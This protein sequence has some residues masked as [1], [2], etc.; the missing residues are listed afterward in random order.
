MSFYTSLTGLNAATAMLGVTSN[1]IANV[2]TTGFKRSRADFGDIFATSPL[3]KASS[4]VGQ[5][6]SLKQVSQEF[7][8]GNISFSSNALDLAIT[9]D[10]FFPMRSAD[11]LQETY[12]RNGSFLLN[13]Q[14]NVVNS[15]GQ[16]LMAATVDSTGSA[17]VNDRVVLTIP[18]KTSGEAKQT[19]AVSLGLN[20]PADAPVISDEFNR[21]NPATYNKSTAFTVYDAGGN[22]YLATV[23]YVKTK[24]A[25]QTSPTNTWQTHVY[26]GEDS[27]NA[28]LQQASNVN[29]EKLYVNQYGQLAPYSLVKDELT[30]AKTMLFSLNDLTDTQKS[31][32]A[33]VPGKSITSFDF[34][35]GD[36]FKLRNDT[37]NAADLALASVAGLAANDSTVLTT[38]DMVSAVVTAAVS[39]MRYPKA[40]LPERYAQGLRAA[41][42]CTPSELSDDAVLL[43]LQTNVNTAV[44]SLSGTAT[45][46][47]VATTAEIKEARDNISYA[48]ILLAVQTAEADTTLTI[49]DILSTDYD[50]QRTTAMDALAAAYWAED[51]PAQYLVDVD[52]AV[53]TAVSDLGTGASENAIA[54]AGLSAKAKLI[55][56]DNALHAGIKAG[57][58]ALGIDTTDLTP[59]EVSALLSDAQLTA[60]QTVITASLG[61]MTNDYYDSVK[62]GLSQLFELDVDGSGEPVILDLG[63]LADTDK[64]IIGNEMAATVTN[65]LNREF[66]DESYFDLSQASDRYFQVYSSGYNTVDQTTGAITES[67][68]PIKLVPGETPGLGVLHNKDGTVQLDSY[69]QPV[70][71][72]KKVT[73]DQMVH[74]I[75]SQLDAANDGNTITASYDFST[76]SFKFLDGANVI[77]LDT[78]GVDGVLKNELFKLS[79][80]SVTLSG[81]GHYE[82]K[83][84][85]NGQAIR[86]AA[87]QRYGMTMTYDSVNK[88]FTMNSGKTGDTS[89]LS[90]TG[91][92]ANS[93]GTDML[94]LTANGLASEA[95]VNYVAQSASALRGIPSTPAVAVGTTP[96]KNIAN[97]FAVDET[98]NKFVVTVDGVKG[99][100]MIPVRSD[101]SLDTLKAELQKGIN[102]LAGNNA[103][104]D[105]VTVNGVQVEYDDTGKR[106]TFTSG[107]TG[108]AS[109]IKISGSA[110]WGLDQVEAARGV[111]STWIKPTQH[112]DVVSGVSQP[113]YIDGQG[114]ETTSGDGFDGTLPAWS[115]IFLTKGELTFST[116][117]KLVSPVDGTQLEPVYLAGGKGVLTINIDYGASTQ[118]TSPFAV[119]S[120]SQ[121]GAPEGDLVG[122]TIG[123]DGLVSASFSNG[124]QKSLAKILLANFSSPVGLRQMGDSTFLA[125]AASGKATLGNAGSA[126]FGTLRAGATERANV[127]LTQELVDLITAQRNFQANA[128]AI[129]TSSTMTSAIINLRA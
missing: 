90:I 56:A 16:R 17:N 61:A 121:D 46:G 71:N 117:G 72:A 67:P 66:G 63:F 112:K 116:G 29:G 83:V 43:E 4:T 111:D 12:T 36:N 32:P 88:K 77:K 33:A 65:S 128:K 39:G 2:G 76:S 48:K 15:A 118:F 9:G 98:N 10:G 50:T 106:F 13:E 104:G 80:T 119:L 120:Q 59:D 5:G 23:Y 18:Q 47:T 95:P 64:K 114:N 100:V 14:Y 107:T 31:V 81:S 103:Y 79:E 70:F 126:G 105:P 11:G 87:D 108:A 6:V 69:G 37:A 38:S 102:A 8:Q 26:V 55:A 122:V 30:T 68:I 97:N 101:Y 42:F 57:A 1:N 115:P 124:T 92:K 22:G 75:Q 7:S 41:V 44:T 58:E 91:V 53:A 129:E 127:D 89:S 84:I 86:L 109:F 51:E 125:S 62:V 85:P 24:N 123:N 25:D 35:N 93:L 3:Q 78:N 74:A 54:A 96:L 27:V 52:A 99:T 21:T 45:D 73:I 60:I 49:S 94:G 19:S 20:F 110:D 28:S 40:D 113:K 82:A 34:S